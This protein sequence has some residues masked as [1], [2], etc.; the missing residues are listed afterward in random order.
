[1]ATVQIRNLDDQAYDV[2]KK[3]AAASGRS[4]Q[5]YLRLLLERAALDEERR[6]FW[7]RYRA[8]MSW[9]GLEISAEEIV[10]RIHEGRRS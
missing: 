6:D 7:K 5:E 8:E 1:M 2:F 4:L 3:R 10:D 9:P